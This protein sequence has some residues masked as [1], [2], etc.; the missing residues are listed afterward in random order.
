MSKNQLAIDINT[1]A[2]RFVKLNGD[3]VVQEKTFSFGDKQDYRYKQQLEE[4]W[5]ETTWK[6]ADFDDVSL[7]WSEKQT[8]LIPVNVF[9]E[10]DKDTIFALSFGKQIHSDGIDYN[11]I[12]VQGLV[13]VYSI[14][15]WVKSFF[16]IRF[17][18][19]VIQ[20]EGT[21]LIRGVFAAQTFKLKTKLIVHQ[22]HFLML[23]VKENN[24]KFY[25]SFEWSSIED[26]VY[27]YSFSIQQL[28]ISEQLNDVE[29]TSGAGAESDWSELKKALETIHSKN[30]SVQIS[31][32]LVEKYQQLCV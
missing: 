21:H 4:F 28:E 12:P 19:I 25:S 9:N 13:N 20:H 8:T 6:E 2:V 24:L 1:S 32:L 11:R 23:I 3:F 29:I 16:V 15:L 10:S 14:P 18:R 17:P 27:Y 5:K 31:N 22:H 30:I 26:I 7:S